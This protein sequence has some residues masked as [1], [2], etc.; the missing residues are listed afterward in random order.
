MSQ[1]GRVCGIIGAVVLF[2]VA[3]DACQA[4]H[5]GR[6]GTAVKQDA[7]QDTDGDSAYHDNDLYLGHRVGRNAQSEVE[8]TLKSYY[9][10]AGGD[11]GRRACALLAPSF[12]Q[13]VP[14]TYGRPP[15]PPALRGTT[16]A[17]VLS[18]FFRQRQRGWSREAQKLKVIGVFAENGR[19]LAILRFGKGPKR[20][21]DVLREGNGWMVDELVDAAAE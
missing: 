4:G 15:G 2:G 3:L 14:R 13:E 19:G 18:A 17:S 21:I 5:S 20:D 12:R 10:L 6:P 7:D 8:R 1:V 16:C 9:E 11:A